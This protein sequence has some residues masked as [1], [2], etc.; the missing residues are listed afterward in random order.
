[1][2]TWSVGI[3]RLI[4]V[5]LLSLI[6]KPLLNL[7]FSASM[8][9]CENLAKACSKG[10]CKILSISFWRWHNHSFDSLFTTNSMKSSKPPPK[11]KKETNCSMSWN[12]SWSKPHWQQTQLHEIPWQSWLNSSFVWELTWS[13]T[14]KNAFKLP[15]ET[16]KQSNVRQF[17]DQF[18]VQ[19]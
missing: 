2:G 9:I 4:S 5:C 15:M 10:F 3:P 17:Q 8:M 13:W 19:V 12:D 18:L 7:V 11:L 1:M 14:V 16:S 6:Q